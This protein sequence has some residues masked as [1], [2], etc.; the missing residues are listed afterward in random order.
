MTLL[1]QLLLVALGGAVG[2]LARFWLSD[3]VARTAGETFPWGTLAVNVSGALAIGI[4]AGLIFSPTDG[5]AQLPSLWLPLITG[6]LGS[7][8]TVSAFS[9]QTLALAQHGHAARAVLNIVGSVVLC[10][11]AVAAGF[12]AAAGG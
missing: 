6:V 10:L 4:L 2:G 12:L 1:G 9:L 5:A 8:T 11:S 7:Y 3:I